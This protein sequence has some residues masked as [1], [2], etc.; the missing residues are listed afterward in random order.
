MTMSWKYGN[1]E[2]GELML[3]VTVLFMITM[4]IIEHLGDVVLIRIPENGL[5]YF[6]MNSNDHYRKGS[7]VTLALV[8]VISPVPFD[9]SEDILASILLVA[10]P[11]L[12][13]LLPSW[14]F[15]EKM[16][17]HSYDPQNQESRGKQNGFAVEWWVGEDD[18]GDLGEGIDDG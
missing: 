18:I 1:M 16:M 15:R 13:Y 9:V 4:M 6:E 10:L 7:S 2:F 11:V 3:E 8:S 14:V 5:K 12:A 17:F